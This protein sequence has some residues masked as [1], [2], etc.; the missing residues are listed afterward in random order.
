MRNL[1]ALLHAAVERDP[2]HDALLWK[3]DGHWHKMTYEVLWQRVQ[4][5]AYGLQQL[6]V[7]TGGK[8]AILSNSRP[9]WAIGDFG[10]LALGAVSVPI[11]PTLTAQQIAFTL[12]NADVEVI[13]VENLEL[14]QT[15]KSVATEDLRYIIVLDDH[16]PL[17]NTDF[18]HYSDVLAQGYAH[19]QVE[20]DLDTWQTIPPDQLATIVH[21]SGTTG[22]PKGVMLTHDNLVQNI[23]HTLAYVPMHPTD[24]TLSYL[25]LSHIFE[26]MAGHY[27]VLGSGATIAYAENLNTIAANLLEIKPTLMTTVP[28]LL[29][30]VYDGVLSNIRNSSKVKQLLFRN[31]LKVGK[32]HRADPTV[33]TSMLH[34]LFDK[35]VFAKIR[36]RT[37]GNIRSFVSGGAALSPAV[38]EF[39][40]AIGLPVC[41]G[42]GLTETSPVIA[43]NPTGEIRIGTVGRVLQNL[44]VKIADDGELLVK[45]PSVMV[46]Y[47]KNPEATEA[48]I[49]EDGWFRTGDIADLQDGY[50]RIV[51][52]K[53]N[54]LVLATGK[55]VAP[56]PVESAISRSPY[57]GQAVLFGD[58]R[59]YVTALIV[60]DFPA[61]K[62]WAEEH[63]LGGLP[64]EEL[65]RQETVRDL[66]QKEIDRKLLHFAPFEKPKR[67]CLLPRD[68]TLEDGELTATLKVRTHVLEAHYREEIEAMYADAA[69]PVADN[70]ATM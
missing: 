6:G 8:V 67:F 10:I 54:I 30:K 44:E 26:R 40:T 65:I 21:T 24:T 52:R 31:A 16:A 70:L 22:N 17:E 20:G 29:E 57:V 48:A 47:Y 43:V 32:K 34:P 12:Q 3:R 63:G 28:R 9:G 53:K 33:L 7:K 5:F 25:P 38:A 23:D 13:L 1:V 35:L 14:A 58:K 64:V 11:Y 18:L 36:E 68:L 55:N 41:E 15:V 37:G 59:K 62:A 39:F 49:D 46:G 56:F 69:Q 66:F 42:Y 4:S 61:L 60:P 27:S 45:G 2:E 50:L 19:L 51:E